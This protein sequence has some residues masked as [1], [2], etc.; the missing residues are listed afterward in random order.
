MVAQVS[1]FA[2]KLLYKRKGKN[3]K[4]SFTEVEN[5]NFVL[6]LNAVFGVQDFGFFSAQHLRIC[7]IPVVSVRLK[8]AL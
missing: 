5:R 4:L 2:D 6:V 8:H 7:L 3:Q 1:R